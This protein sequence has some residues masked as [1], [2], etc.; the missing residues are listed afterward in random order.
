MGSFKSKLFS[1]LLT[2]G[3]EDCF[4]LG[5]EIASGFVAVSVSFFEAENAVAT[6]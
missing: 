3:A 2:F 4:V 1:T 5:G 6:S